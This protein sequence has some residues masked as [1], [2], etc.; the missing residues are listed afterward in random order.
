MVDEQ[1]SRVARLAAETAL[2]RVIHHYGSRPE[3]VVIGGLVPELLCV[4][5]EFRHA[6][7]TDIDV[8]VN[9]EIACGAVNTARL[10]RALRNAEFVPTSERIWRWVVDEGQGRPKTLVKFEL[11]A[12]LDTTP[13]GDIFSFEGCKDLGAVNLRG[14]AFAARHFD[15]VNL[16]AKVSDT[17]YEVQVNVASIAGFICPS[18]E[19]RTV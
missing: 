9:L 8:Q 13:A 7:T 11:L 14:T 3:F 1:R 12:D 19:Y 4:G 15:V 10:E 5:S 2:V 17:T 6:G 16:K 18:S